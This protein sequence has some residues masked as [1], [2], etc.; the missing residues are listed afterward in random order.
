MLKDRKD[1]VAR[2]HLANG[3]EVLQILA[4]ADNSTKRQ[5]QSWGYMV[6]YRYR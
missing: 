3:A 5:E 4:D 2:F 1:P 6:N